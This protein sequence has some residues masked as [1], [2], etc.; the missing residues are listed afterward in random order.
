M[1]DR[2]ISDE[3]RG[4]VRALAENRCGYCLSPQHLVLGQLEIEHITPRARGGSDE[5]TNLWLACRLCNNSKGV[6][7]EGL[8]PDTNQRVPLF[9]PRR[10]SWVDHFAWNTDGTRVLGLTP[11][12]RATVLALQLNGLIA[13]T[14]RR[15]WVAAGWHPP[16]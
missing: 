13:V 16:R 7:T 1:T 9:D 14:V 10:Q 2:R 6:Q 11:C 8:D 15:C 4:R 5:E 3:V 12:G